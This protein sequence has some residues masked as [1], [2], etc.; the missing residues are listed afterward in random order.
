[1]QTKVVYVWTLSVILAVEFLAPTTIPELE[2]V[3]SS[4]QLVTV[5]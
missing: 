5:S 4:I 1:M 2:Q 3:L